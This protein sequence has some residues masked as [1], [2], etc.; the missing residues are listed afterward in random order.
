MEI[1]T[2]TLPVDDFVSVKASDFNKL[3]QLS[4][5]GPQQVQYQSFKNIDFQQ[6]SIRVGIWFGTR[7]SEVQILSPRPILSTTYKR[8]LSPALSDVGDFEAAKASKINQELS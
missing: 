3:Q 4:A 5:S 7:G 6:T 2:K 8:F 1:R